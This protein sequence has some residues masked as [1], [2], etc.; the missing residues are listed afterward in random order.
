[1]ATESKMEKLGIF[2]DSVKMRHCHG[3]YPFF[4]FVFS[5]KNSW[6][7]F[8]YSLLNICSED[9]ERKKLTCLL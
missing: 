4:C 3:G 7:L 2:W 6:G 5:L 8:V 1:M 9:I